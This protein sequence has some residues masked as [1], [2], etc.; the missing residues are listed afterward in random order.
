[1]NPC[2]QEIRN[3]VRNTLS[4]IYRATQRM[5]ADLTLASEEGGKILHTIAEWMKKNE[6]IK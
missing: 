4:I 3:E 2:C 6:G 5:L 1:M